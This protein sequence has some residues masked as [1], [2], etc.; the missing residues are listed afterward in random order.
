M[1]HSQK[2]SA[3]GSKNKAKEI[4][5]LL[6]DLTEGPHPREKE[7]FKSNHYYFVAVVVYL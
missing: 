3:T 6:L 5:L 4:G 7:T 2:R 1:K